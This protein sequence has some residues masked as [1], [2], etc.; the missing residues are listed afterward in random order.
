MGIIPPSM[1]WKPLVRSAVDAVV[2]APVAALTAIAS[3]VPPPSPSP[4]PLDYAG[5]IMDTVEGRIEQI[6]EPR[7]LSDLATTRDKLISA[8]D[9]QRSMTIVEIPV[10]KMLRPGMPTSAILDTAEHL[11]RLGYQLLLE[12]HQQVRFTPD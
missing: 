11:Q 5:I 1:S 9:G 2:N 8:S 6:T 10:A 4:E 3:T 12:S 7:T